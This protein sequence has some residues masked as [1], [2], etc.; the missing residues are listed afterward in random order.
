MSNIKYTRKPN[1]PIPIKV[2]ANKT[3]GATWPPLISIENAVP[4]ADPARPKPILIANA[5]ANS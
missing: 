1:K 4:N 3:A 2:A 5:S